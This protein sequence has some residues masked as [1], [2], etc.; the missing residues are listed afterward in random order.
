VRRQRASSEPD[1]THRRGAGRCR[2]YPAHQ[3]IADVS[4]PYRRN[5]RVCDTGVRRSRP[6]GYILLHP[7][8]L[9]RTIEAGTGLSSGV[10]SWRESRRR[11]TFE[12]PVP[13]IQR[14][15]IRLAQGWRVSA[16][17]VCAIRN[18]FTP[19]GVA[20]VP[21]PSDRDTS[22]PSG[23]NAVF[24][25]LPKVARGLANLGLNGWN[26]S[27]YLKRGVNSRVKVLVAY[28]LRAANP[29]RDSMS[30]NP[31]LS[32]DPA[33][34]LMNSKFSQ[35]S[36]DGRDLRLHGACVF[37]ELSS[38]TRL[39]CNNRHR[40]RPGTGPLVRATETS[41]EIDSRDDRDG[42]SGAREDSCLR[43]D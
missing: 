17:L 37:G 29:S 42:R 25:A 9:T 26:P 16:Y 43:S 28:Q 30:E 36:S 3:S 40:R 21:R 27:G 10:I 22:T 34:G 38:M 20:S 1:Q 12:P 11:P 23:L 2:L 14:D 19:T 4:F 18:V 35:L 15:C 32:P 24:V 8:S 39:N 41:D 31:P 7:N 33:T 13:T 5:P 6:R